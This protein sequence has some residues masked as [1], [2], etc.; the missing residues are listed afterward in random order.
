M[1][2]RKDT[3]VCETCGATLYV[4]SWPFCKGDA[5]SHETA[6]SRWAQEFKPVVVFVKPDGTLRV[7]ATGD[8]RT[9]RGYERRELTNRR[10]MDKFLK[11]QS[12]RERLK[13]EGVRIKED[14]FWGA[15]LSR[16]RADVMK[17]AEGADGPTRA[18][19]ETVC[20]EM[21]KRDAQRNNYDPG[22]YF[23]AFENWEGRR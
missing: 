17:M 19:I 11:T 3:E 20:R 5:A 2:K 8:E 6:R 1:A 18:F 10:E 7:P 12:D 16:N 14:G 15:Q 23:D 4:G 9:P 13:A 21:D 22:L